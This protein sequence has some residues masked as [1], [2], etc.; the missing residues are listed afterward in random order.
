MKRFFSSY[1]LKVAR[2]RGAVLAALVAFLSVLGVAS[3]AG[4]DQKGLNPLASAPGVKFNGVDI[5]G[6]KYAQTLS[7]PDSTG[8]V[9]SLDEFKGKVVMVFFG[10]SQWPVI[11]P[12]T[13]AEIAVLRRR[14]GP[15]GEQVQGVFVSVDP[16]RDTPEVLGAYVKALDPSF[17]GLRGSVEQVTA[18]AREFKVFFQKVPSK[19]GKTYTMDHTAGSYLFDPQGRVRLFQRYGLGIDALQSDVKQLLATP[20]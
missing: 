15:Q 12:S 20:T 16:E 8:K 3:M 13:M 17:V 7:L 19:D 14:L 4:C 5:T 6:A 1:R 9:R 2:R 11:C 18:A 10:F